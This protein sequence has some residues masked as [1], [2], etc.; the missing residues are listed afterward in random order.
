MSTILF[1]TWDGGGNVPPALA[2]A[3]ELARRGHTV[4]VLGHAT[5]Q[6][7]VTAAGLPFRAYPS[8]R[9]FS[10]AAANSPVALARTFGDRAMG[11]DVA[12]ELD[13]RPADLVVVDCL[14]FGAMEA[15]AR[16]GTPYVVLEHFFDGY[17]RGPGL[18]NPLGLGLWL[19]GLRPRRLLDGAALCLVASLAALDPGAT[20]PAGNVVHTGPFVTGV[21]TRPETPTVL[22]SLSTYRFPGMVPVWQRVLDGVADLPVRVI[23]TT[24]PV[25]EPADLRAGANTDLRSWAPHAEVMPTVSAVVGHGG[26]S[27]TMLALAHVLPMVVIPMYALADQPMVGRA[28]RDAGA[29]IALGKKASAAAVRA[30]VGRVL[31]EPAYGAAAA[32][33]GRQ[34]RDLDGLHRAADLVAGLVP[35]GIRAR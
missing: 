31:E 8:A 13:A 15:V 14:L 19:S 34:V 5:Q 2:L 29:G 17:L 10:S 22:V 32:R 27:T 12:A 24:G 16:R 33:L 21:P 18:R 11:A 1:V 30:A 9:P 35:N 25:V 26:H 20:A 23:A 7:E 28:V 6:R 4:R 3:T